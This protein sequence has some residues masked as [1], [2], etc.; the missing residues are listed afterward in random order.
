MNTKTKFAIASC[1]LVLIAALASDT[2]LAAG[3][4]PLTGVVSSEPDWVGKI[5]SI[6]SDNNSIV[7][8]DR[9]FILQSNTLFHGNRAGRSGLRTGMTVSIKYITG[10]GDVPIATEISMQ[11]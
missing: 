11:Q 7:V 10:A 6:N 1:A 3:P 2:T 4:L 8:N 9:V 5:D